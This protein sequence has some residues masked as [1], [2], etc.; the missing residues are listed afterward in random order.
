MMFFSREDPHWYSVDGA[1][2]CAGIVGKH[3]GIRPVA[4][5]EDDEWHKIIAVNLTGMMYSL[6]AELR[7]I[8]DF[9]SS[10]FHRPFIPHYE[11]SCFEKKKKGHARKKIREG[12]R[13]ETVY[14]RLL[15]HLTSC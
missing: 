3:H 15:T 9:G 4:E 6:R 2:N 7:K 5:L 14:N 13:G 10:M 8:S 12:G 1:A 11:H